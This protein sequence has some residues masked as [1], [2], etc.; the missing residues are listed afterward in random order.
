MNRAV[1]DFIKKARAGGTVYITS[2]REA[3]ERLP[4]DQTLIFP[5]AVEMISGGERSF[6]LTLPCFN[7][8]GLGSASEE[9][10]F[11][12]SYFLAELY[13]ILSGLGARSLRFE[14]PSGSKEAVF[15]YDAFFREFGVGL[16]RVARRGCGRSI[17]VIERMLDAVDGK[18]RSVFVCSLDG[19]AAV[20]AAAVGAMASSA[21]AV[22]AGISAAPRVPPVRDDT[23]DV[24]HTQAAAHTEAV[25]SLRETAL[26]GVQDTTLLGIDIGGTDIKLA[27]ASKGK[28]IALREYDWF[29]ASFTTIDQLIDPI[30]DL[31]EKLIEDF[32]GECSG[33]SGGGALG[34]S[35]GAPGQPAGNAEP[36]LLDGIGVS[37]PDVV[38]RDKIVGGEVYKTRGIRENPAIDYDAEFKRLSHLDQRLRRFVKP[39][40]TVAVINDGPMAAFTAAV[41]MGAADPRSVEDGVFAHTLGTELGTGWVT[42]AGRIP[43]IP[44][45]VYN[46]IIDL[47]SW[48]ERAFGSDD[49]RSVNNFNTGLPGTL[50]KYTSQSGAFRL[51]LK[52]FP[53]SRPDIYREILDAGYIVHTL[54][55]D[56]EDIIQVPTEPQDQRKPFLEYLMRLPARGSDAEVERIF[57]EIG[58]Y[59]AIAY[60]ECERILDPK[61]KARILFGRMVK[62]PLCFSLLQK[63]ARR[64]V[65]D[66]DLSVVDDG[67]AMTPLMRELKASPYPVAQFAQAVGA[68]YYAAYRKGSKHG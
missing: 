51:A 22:S 9:T 19:N 3:F 59:M 57:T 18:D 39:K 58:E 67:M 2:V 5:V 14:N 61:V 26:G 11:I 6:V 53:L 43:D 7:A 41:E 48:P 20:G 55:A 35:T 65:P 36:F 54:R 4:A 46:F 27:L 37:F 17:N 52:Y 34:R 64:I 12:R 63:G 49:G 23:R 13:N 68:V 32:A 8:Y 1:S 10:T 45:E 28:L 38:V 56:G 33:I 47:G 16:D 40:G 62:N 21:M 25:Q 66:I 15:L 31:V 24:P 42:G 44:L 60:R 30:V 29:P 50:Q